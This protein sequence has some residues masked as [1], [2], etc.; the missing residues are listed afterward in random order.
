VD[1]DSFGDI[2]VAQI[3]IRGFHVWSN[4]W[5]DPLS[6]DI[7]TLISVQAA[8]VGLCAFQ[9]DLLRSRE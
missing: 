7:E 9:E 1:G 6:D 8:H 4:E 2:I 3:L 5:N